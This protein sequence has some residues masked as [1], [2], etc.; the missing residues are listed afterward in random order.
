MKEETT[1][2]AAA[3]FI[4]N[5]EGKLLEA[6]TIQFERLS[7][8]SVKTEIHVY[9]EE[10]ARRMAESCPP[11]GTLIRDRI[12]GGL[13]ELVTAEMDVSI[14]YCALTDA[15]D[16]L[17]Q[18]FKVPISPECKAEAAKMRAIIPV[19]PNPAKS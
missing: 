3:F 1:I 7:Q 17:R 15:I 19:K 16:N 9:K 14:P 10:P 4:R 12:S 8:S 18:H 2:N 13:I 6:G 5:E 11:G